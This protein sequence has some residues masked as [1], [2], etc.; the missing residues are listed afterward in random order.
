MGYYTRVTGEIR[1]D[2]PLPWA[3]IGGS[4]FLPDKAWHAELCVKLRVDVEE[5]D[6]DEGTLTRRTA[7]AVEPVTDESFKAYT[8]TEDL[9]KLV[10]WA[11][12]EHRFVGRFSCEGEETGDLWRLHVVDGRAV[13]VRPTVTWPDE[14]D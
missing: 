8:L 2:P 13:E 10:D 1:I 6:T 9:Q 5:V 7:T 12:S 11:G 3:K 14:G 4:K